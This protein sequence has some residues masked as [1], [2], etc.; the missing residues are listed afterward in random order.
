MT[1]DEY[2]VTL[3]ITEDEAQR[4]VN[5][6]NVREGSLENFELKASS[7]HGTGFFTL[8]NHTEG[9]QIG[10][11]RFNDKR[12]ELG[13]WVNHSETPNASLEGDYV[14]AL[15]NI[16]AGEEI[17]MCYLDNARKQCDVIHYTPMEQLEILLRAK[18]EIFTADEVPTVVK[19]MPNSGL[20]VRYVKLVA[21]SV[22]LGK[23][24]KEWSLNILASGSMYVMADPT[25]DKLK[26]EA[27]YVFETG[28]GS[29]KFV[30]CITD[31]VFMNVL[32]SENESID[33][34]ENRMASNSRITKLIEKERLCQV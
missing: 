8:V 26:V 22:Y 13:R 23:V 24:H 33:D 11:A 19:Q 17:T 29:Q 28:P 25:K 30:M 31:C 32:K 6:D 27:P 1:Y 5:M 18:H 9:T 2:L 7:I 4:L 10:L 12:T 21:G 20:G 3:G 14:V 15:G 34:M 16:S